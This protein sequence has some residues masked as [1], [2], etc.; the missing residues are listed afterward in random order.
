[1]WLP[2]AGKALSYPIWSYLLLYCG[3]HLP[4]HLQPDGSLVDRLGAGNVLTL[5]RG[6]LLALLGGFLLGS[7]PTGFGRWLPMVAYTASDLADYFDGYLARSQG[8]ATRLGQALDL[9]LDALGLLLAV[10]VAIHFASLPWWFIFFGLARYGF[11]FL[12]RLRQWLQL[13]VYALPPSKARRPIAGLSMGYVSA[14]L[15]PILKPAELTLAGVVFMSAFTASF[16]RDA[17]AVAGLVRPT[18]HRYRRLRSRA[19]SILLEWLPLLPRLGV[20]CLILL[21]VPTLLQ[22]SGTLLD[23]IQAPFV[24]RLL[25]AVLG[26]GGLAILLGWAGRLAAFTALFPFG[27]LLAASS[28]TP[29]RRLLLLSLLFILMLGSGR[30][31][32]WQPTDSWFAQRA[33]A[34][35]E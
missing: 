29:V 27:L 31:S 16:V 18:G 35:Q 1:M 20:F 2:P 7:E 19:R 21:E 30:F 17:L 15:W 9:E 8:L 11:T 13:P 5:A 4:F 34:R 25:G 6:W 14:S 22:P 23:F 12:V 3:W 28:L 10:G 26:M 33:G 32:L 24:W